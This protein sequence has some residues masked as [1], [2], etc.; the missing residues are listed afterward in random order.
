MNNN[1]K[2][3]YEITGIITGNQRFSLHDGPGIRTVI[4][5]KGCPLSCLWCHNPETQS[6]EPEI[7]FDAIKCIG[8]GAC[9]SVC[10]YGCHKMTE[11]VHSFDRSGC[12]AC[13]KCVSVC[14]CALEMC[15]ERV[16]LAQALKPVLADRPFYKR[17]G[18]LTLSGGEPFAQP[19][20]ATAL[21]KKAKDE[22][23]STAVE[24]CG[25]VKTEHLLN[26]LKYT[27][28]YL[29]DIKEID[30]VKHR[31][32]VGA[33]NSLILNN[34]QMLSDTGAK[35]ILRVPVVPDANDSPARFR[36]I[37]ELA[38]RLSGVVS[39]DLLPYHRAGTV[40]YGKLG[41]ETREYHVPNREE[42]DKYVDIVRRYTDKPVKIK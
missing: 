30:P 11:G 16:S 35:I 5:L 33:D 41:L 28:L 15:G 22:G 24:T 40:K 12:V 2:N 20:F 39:V 9:V 8:C 25:A 13:G 23:I 42:I 21:L 10:E 29:Y 1:L 31:E 7:L 14:P 6:Y 38:Q 26:S 17:E 36:A 19:E 3:E 18:G 32:L 4:F 37:G 34:L 27:D